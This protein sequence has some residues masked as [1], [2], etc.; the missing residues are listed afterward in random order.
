MID[1]IEHAM[2]ASDR[3]GNQ[4]ALLFLDLDSFKT[5]N[6]TLGH[7]MGDV[8]LQQVAERLSCNIRKDN[9]VSR[10][11]GDEFVVLLV[12][13]NAKPIEAATQAEDIAKKILYAINRPYR[14]DSNKYASSTSIGITLFKAHESEVKDLLKKADIAMYRAKDDD[15]NTLR[16]FYPQMQAT[17]TAQA[18]LEKELNQAIEQQQFQLYY[19]IQVD[20]SL[21]PLGAEGLIRGLHPQRGFISPINFIPL[22]ESNGEILKIGQW[23]LDN[24]FAQLKTWQQDALTRDLTLSVNVSS[25]QFG[26]TDFISQVI[27]TTQQHNINPARLKLELTESLL[28][29]DIEDIIA[30]IKTLAKIGI[31]FSLD[32]FEALLNSN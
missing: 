16:F 25:K 1:R 26:Q 24:A 15:R 17:I 27:M 10:F 28:Q 18:E 3:S 32:E 8:L 14:L 2:A 19:Q 21:R 9:T 4:S 31:Q 30:K 11:G 6:D 23:V 12:G 29:E 22:T 13:L 5:L 20:S 7:N